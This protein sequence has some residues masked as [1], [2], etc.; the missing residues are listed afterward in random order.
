MRRS[1]PWF[2][3]ALPPA[4]LAVGI[5]ARVRDM[6]PPQKSDSPPQPVAVD[7]RAALP[8]AVVHPGSPSHHPGIEVREATLAPEPPRG[9]AADSP[10]SVRSAFSTFTPETW[11][12]LSFAIREPGSPDRRE[13]I[14]A[15]SNWDAADEPFS[16]M[17]RD[18]LLEAL[19]VERDPDMQCV[20]LDALENHVTPTAYFVNVLTDV[21]GRETSQENR[22]RL[23][24][25]LALVAPP[26]RT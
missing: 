19:A 24:D 14:R 26:P 4:A 22:E 21:Y 2:L 16:S 6:A 10:D 3:L 18:L 5:L 7:A 9:L 17:A 11:E 20:I 23:L 8:S 25:L 12:V 1:R 13:A 15:A